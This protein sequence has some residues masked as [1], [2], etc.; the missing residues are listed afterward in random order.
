M[1]NSSSVNRK[2]T[3]VVGGG[4]AGAA[5]AVT[6]AQNNHE[7]HW[8]ESSRLLGWRA[9][10]V[11]VR[12]KNLDNGQHIMLGAYTSC[13][14]LLKALN[15][16]NE[17]CFLR[18]PLQMIYPEGSGMQFIAPHLPAPLHL[19]FAL[20]RAQGLS[21]ED[22]MALARFS[23]TARWMDWQ[24]NID[25]SVTELLQRYQ[26]T[27]NLIKLMW[28][29]LC[30]AALNTP[31]DRA[32]A[33]VFLAVLRDSL[34]AKRNASD[35]LIP[36]LDLSALLP[37]AAA[38]FVEA[39]GGQIRLGAMV[40]GLEKVESNR[41]QISCPSLEMG[42]MIYDSVV[43][44]TPAET[45]KRMLKDLADDQAIVDT[46]PAEFPQDFEYEAITTCYL[47]YASST[48]LKR[49]F[50]A[51]VDDPDQA[52][53]GQFVFDRGQLHQDQSGLLAVVISAAANAIAIDKDLLVKQIAK[54][55]ADVLHM[56]ELSQPLW[57]QVISEKRATFSCTPD[58][59]RPLNRTSHT[60]LVLAGDYTACDYPATLESAVRSGIAAAQFLL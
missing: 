59:Q 16:N 54:Q 8:L 34:G 24:L 48:S 45:S 27:E 23:T 22:K 40:Q 37:E 7:V 5:A 60:G 12:G 2:K 41:W 55:L 4:W 1:K 17:Q 51:L 6:L 50:F 46:S 49:P 25:C 21:R 43:L 29:P 47:Q 58:L 42:A 56:P 26:Q 3:A 36:K 38:R 14:K 15:L 20:L 57:H 18:L 53:W 28:N 11:E 33:R 30:I 39:K 44:A 19:A 13:L 35:M 9:R 31:P 32:S 52:H 10:K